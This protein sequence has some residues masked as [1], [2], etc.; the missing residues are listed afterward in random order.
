[1]NI[2]LYNLNPPF[3]IHS[4]IVNAHRILNSEHIFDKYKKKNDICESHFKL[5]SDRLGEDNLVFPSF[6]YSFANTLEFDISKDESQVG[7]LSEWVR[8]R[9]NFYRTLTPF[10]SVL[11]K[12][13]FI[14]YSSVQQPFGKG[15]SFEKMFDLDGTFIFYGTDFSIFT[16]IHY[17]ENVLGP[18]VYRYD[19]IFEGVVINNNIKKKITVN[20]HVRPKDS[21]LDY[22]WLKMQKDLIK[23]NILIPDKK[24][25]LLYFANC[26]NLYNFF[27]NQLI[28]DKFYM[29]NNESKKFF[30]K[31]T[32]FGKNRLNISEFE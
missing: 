25:S 15:S 6:N 16:A 1:M 29:L 27:E 23:K 5:L 14:N 31:I 4:D 12:N 8:T 10:F 24:H 19:K 32:K 9:T 17:L 20:L 13:P 26:K 30:N 7:S 3:F 18:V 2:N 22:D 28:N 21:I 11:S